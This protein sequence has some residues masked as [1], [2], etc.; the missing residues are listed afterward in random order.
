MP[1][2]SVIIPVYNVEKYLS[3]CL[4]SVLKSA[5]TDIEVIVIDDGSTDRCPNIID[6]YA[7]KDKRIVAFHQKNCGYGNAMNTGMKYATG[8][9]IA[10]LEADDYI[11]INM[12]KDLYDIAKKFDSD[13][14]K[15][16]FYD[17]FQYAKNNK[18]LKSL[19]DTYVPE[20]KCFTLKEY[21]C[22]L[23][24]HP[25]IWSAI[26]KREF[27]EQNGIKFVEAP[28]AGWTDNLFQIQTLCL[29]KKINYTSSAYYYWRKTNENEA[30]DLKDYRI[31]FLRSNEI[32]QWL[33]SNNITDE[34]ILA[35]L[36]RR[37]LSYI[38]LVLSMDKIENKTDCFAK[39]RNLCKKM[40]KS[41]IMN[42]ENIKNS[43]RKQ[44]LQC[45][46]NPAKM[47]FLVQLNKYTKQVIRIRLTKPEIHIV[48]F[49]KTLVRKRPIEQL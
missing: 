25:S 6:R 44:Y 17:Y 8:E 35:C 23:S 1:K 28:G 19:W 26:Y 48:L 33:D 10:I 29:A 46:N 15:S 34:N 41:I 31:P 16:S 18:V 4:D 24:Y 42:N 13:I 2:V 38:N 40:K 39:I 11:D 32:H 30:D 27:M 37:E 43:E 47:R 45:L 5:L 3:V 7:E 49:G 12:Y 21:P 22:F 20:D 14:V 9:Y 36:Y